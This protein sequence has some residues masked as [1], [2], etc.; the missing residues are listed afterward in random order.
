MLLLA[1]GCATTPSPS[2]SPA[3]P[4]V[5]SAPPPQA[6]IR[7]ARYEDYTRY[8]LLSPETA[9]FKIQYETAATAAGATYYFNPIRKGSEAT[10]ERVFDFAS[11]KPLAFEVVSGATA[12]QTGLADA[13]LDTQYIRVAL[14]RPVP[15]DGLARLFIE[16]TYRDPK[17]YFLEGEAIVFARSLGIRRNS[18]VLPAGWELIACNVP[19]Q[20]LSEPDGRIQVSFL[21]SSP[22]PAS[23]ILKARRIRP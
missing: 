23:L 15:P 1:A 4:T 19:S 20:V 18:V 12:R 8:E 17:S 11:G 9:Q 2:P 3:P 16:K 7:E 10:D 13:D 22:D 21:N 6:V 5:V 14:A